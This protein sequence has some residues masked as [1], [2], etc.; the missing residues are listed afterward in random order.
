MSTKNQNKPAPCRLAV[1]PVAKAAATATRQGP[2]R[3]PRKTLPP[4]RK[5]DRSREELARLAIDWP[6]ALLEDMALG[7]DTS[8]ASLNAY[9]SGQRR[10]TDAVALRLAEWLRGRAAEALEVAAQLE[11]AAGSEAVEGVE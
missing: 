11:D 2:G 3:R 8:R 9:R 10:M 5:R 7:A 1:R 4:L 6:R